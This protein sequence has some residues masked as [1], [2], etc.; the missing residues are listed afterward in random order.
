[1]Q[2]TLLLTV[3][4]I[5][6]TISAFT[7]NVGIGIT[8]PRFPLS[9][10][11]AV[12]QKVSFWDNGNVT[13]SNY[14]IGVQSGLLQIHANEPADNIAFGTGSSAN[15]T[16][17]F[18][19]TGSG[20]LGLNTTLPSVYGHGGLGTVLEIQ[21]PYAAGLSPHS[22]LVLSTK[23]TFGHVGGLTWA[24]TALNGEKRIAYIGTQFGS[25]GTGELLFFTRNNVG[26]LLQRM[27]L[28]GA[29]TLRLDGPTTLASGDKVI[30]VGGYG[31]LQVDAPGIAGGR[32]TLAENGYL[33]LNDNT[34]GSRLDVNGDINMTGALKMNGNAGAAGQLMISNGNA[35]P[36]WTSASNVIKSQ[37][38]GE[39]VIGLLHLAG[40]HDMPDA[41]LNISLPTDSRVYLYYKTA[42]VGTCGIGA[43]F[44]KW[45]L[46]VY[47]NG[48]TLVTY[49]IDGVN[50]A[51]ESADAARVSR[52]LGPDIIDLPA[53]NHVITFKARNLRDAPLAYLTSVAI[54]VAR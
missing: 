6:L 49:V 10:S 9:F 43:C 21:N 39:Q 27:S 25:S 31:S 15:F 30:S 29:G 24:S 23:S 14:G 44:P 3:V 26:T 4:L 40:Y 52:A 50:V 19:I 18:R 13:G 22:Q 8:T 46:S 51:G 5:T 32:F 33:G 16:E 17:H 28:N 53:G 41:A 34:P 48:N 20:N 42:T 11:T 54:A 2:R 38:A 47:L 36:V 1:M 45:E 35:L 12:G 37:W 7:Q